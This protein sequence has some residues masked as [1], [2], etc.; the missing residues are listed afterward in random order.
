M[1]LIYQLRCLICG[2]SGKLI[3]DSDLSLS[4]IPLIFMFLFL[5]YLNMIFF[6]FVI[7]GRLQEEG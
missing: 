3:S 6:L 5:S 7:K 2:V 4:A 1:N